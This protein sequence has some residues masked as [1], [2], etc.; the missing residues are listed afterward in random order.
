[1]TSIVNK[2]FKHLTRE[3]RDIIEN[4]LTNSSSILCIANT[5][6]RDITTISKEIKRHRLL[7]LPDRFNN[8][9][10]LC[11]HRKEC[12]MFNCNESKNCF[13]LICP[14]LKKSPYVCNGCEKKSICRNAKYY[15]YSK[16]AHN[17]YSDTLSISRS[18][19]RI[20][21]D[22]E[23]KIEN[24]IY[25]LIKNKNQSINEIYINNPDLLSFS[26][27]TLY[28]YIDQGLFN[29]KNQDLRRKIKY[30][31]RKNGIKR[32]RIESKIR[33]DRTYDD[34]LNFI[35]LHPNMNIVEMDCVEGSKG[36][37]V[38]LTFA[39]RKYNLLLIFLLES[40]SVKCVLEVFNYLKNVLGKDLFKK[41]FRIILT[42]NGSE[43][44]DPDSIERIDN[45]KII[46]LFFCDSGKS[47]QKGKI[48]KLHEYI[49]YVLPKGSTFDYLIQEDINI[50]MSNINSSS[51]L[52]S[53]KHK[54]PYLAFKE[55]Y[56]L[57]TLK[58][59]N[60]DYVKPNEVNLS[61]KLLASH[62]ERKKV[63]AKL[64]NDLDNY[65]Q[66]KHLPKLNYDIKKYIINYYINDYYKYRPEDL[67]YNSLEL[68][69]KYNME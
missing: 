7:K 12:K 31:P 44:F 52:S 67:F 22:E 45:K 4:L 32:T 19:V 65:N 17:D 5:L 41:L 23:L 64:I 62:I 63:L 33:T 53:G 48:E 13:D 18:G 50:L 21:K 26:K 57:H 54:S 25:D 51:R 59:F 66:T 29:L 9:T 14:L 2:K 49:R 58:L 47:Y 55:E 27:P 10:N 42:D 61:K 6:S 60:I 16:N 15:Y 11:I 36:G 35:N 3:E 43:F 69:D 30:K 34:F 46:N 56:G 28:S 40:Q 1:M 39:F 68:I 38:F 24:V 20:S 8:Q 37:K